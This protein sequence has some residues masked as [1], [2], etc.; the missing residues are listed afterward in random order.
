M[1]SICVLLPCVVAH[2]I[3]SLSTTLSVV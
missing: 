3:V 1:G 2:S